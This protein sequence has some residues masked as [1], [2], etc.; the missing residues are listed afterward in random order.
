MVRLEE[1]E[2]GKVLATVRATRTPEGKVT[3]VSRSLPGVSGD[4]VRLRAGRRYRVVGVYDNPTPEVIKRGAMAHLAGLFA[5]DDL[6][7]W[8]AIDPSDE[9]L[10]ADL[11][12]LNEMG[13][14]TH[15]HAKHE[16]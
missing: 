4:G 12:S 3:R 6:A 15:P 11:T 1:V 2:S 7:R 8:P 10:Q 16:H 13:K 9:T 5:P 14:A